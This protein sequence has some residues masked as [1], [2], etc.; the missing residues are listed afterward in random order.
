M[1]KIKTFRWNAT[2]LTT[3][4][5]LLF[6]LTFAAEDSALAAVRQAHTGT[7]STPAAGANQPGITPRVRILVQPKNTTAED[8]LQ[9]V[10]ASLEAIW[11]DD[12]IAYAARLISGSTRNIGGSLRPAKVQSRTSIERPNIR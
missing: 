8:Q 9:N 5:A 10:F 11:S 2:P 12:S 4:V 1:T 3:C 6:L 7:A